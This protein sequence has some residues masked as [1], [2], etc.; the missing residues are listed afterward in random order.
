MSVYRDES[1]LKGLLQGKT[2]EQGAE[3]HLFIIIEQNVR[4][5]IQEAIKYQRHFRKKQ[6]NSQD[7]ELAIKDQNMLK[8]EIVGFQYMDSIN[9]SKRMDEYVLNDQSLDLRDLITHQMKTVKIPLGF[10]SLSIFNVMKDYQMINSQETQSIMQYKDIIQAESFQIME[11]KKSF[12][13]IKDN[14]ISI[15]TV[16]Q[17]S[18]VKN[19]KDIFEKEV[20]S[21]KFNFSQ[22]FV[23][24]LSDLE[25][26]KD[27]AQIV[28]FIIQYLYS[29]Q[30][31]VQIY[32]YKHRCVIIE[33][34]NK[35]IVNKQI[36]LEFQLHQILKILVQFLTAK[37][38]KINI[39]S[40]IELQIKTAKCLNYLLEKFNL[41]YQAL[42][43]NIDRVILDKFEK[44][45][46]KIQ[47]KNSHKS[48]LKVYSIISYFIE[49]NVN[50]QHLKFV[51]QMCELIRNIEVGKQQIKQ[52]YL[53]YEHL[54]GLISLSLGSILMKVINGLQYFQPK[55][56]NKILHIINNTRQLMLEMGLN[57]MLV[58][59]SYI[60]E[61]MIL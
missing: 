61:H 59:Q 50:V 52:Q 18:I 42:R 25:N 45:K 30:D 44:I 35:L 26:Y 56:E 49:Q 8:S 7:I 29:Q 24:L 39:K 28:P 60:V 14:V 1:I 48:L 22:E 3:L 57:E 21:L 32:Y 27:V 9:L 4:K 19:F 40:Q 43:Q 15:L 53:D 16:H 10:P 58:M 38:V 34:L 54:A 20:T 37:I 46:S 51:E 5:V 23:Q 31:Q 33:C 41:K 47:R 13:I 12:N 36:N 11:N 6:L 17:Q 55:D 2:I